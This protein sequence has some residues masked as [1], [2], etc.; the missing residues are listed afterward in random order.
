MVNCLPSQ[1]SERVRVECS[2]SGLTDGPTQPPDDPI[3][4]LGC[5][6]ATKRQDQYLLGVKIIVLNSVCDR[7]D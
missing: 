1:Q 5:R 6:T 7:F 2:R 4:K 3:P